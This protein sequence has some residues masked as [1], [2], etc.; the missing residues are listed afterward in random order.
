[1][2]YTK[3]VYIEITTLEKIDNEHLYD[4][5]NKNFNKSFINLKIFDTL[6]YKREQELNYA[7]KSKQ[8]SIL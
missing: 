6:N 8:I 2:P 4:V 5:I 1:M 7:K 3:R